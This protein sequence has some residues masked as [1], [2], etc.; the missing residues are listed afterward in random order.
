MRLAL[1]VLCA[2][3][4]AAL[5]AA[6]LAAPPRPIIGILTLP[7]TD[8]DCRSSQSF[9]ASYVKFVEAAGGRVV[10]IPYNATAEQV[11]QLFSQLNGVLFTGGDA[12]LSNGSPFFE[13]VKFIFGLVFAMNQAGTYLPL[14][15]TCLGFE[16]IVCACSGD[17]SILSGNFD[18]WNYPV[19]ITPTPAAAAVRAVK[20]AQHAH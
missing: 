2:L 20:A 5:V 4:A 8:S 17:P 6:A 10:P 9:P 3:V 15:G 14:W 12:D 7:C 13:Q 1:L 16:A 11:I 19:A 18:S